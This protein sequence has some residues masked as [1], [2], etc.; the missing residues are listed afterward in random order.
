[1]NLRPPRPER[2]LFARN[3][4]NSSV[5]ASDHVRT[6]LEHGANRQERTPGILPTHMGDHSKREKRRQHAIEALER[7]R[8]SEVWT[9]PP[10][11]CGAPATHEINRGSG[12]VTFVCEKHIPDGLWVVGQFEN[13]R[14]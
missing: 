12:K 8:Q 3:G 4:G 2:G 5:F 1:M 13:G 14:A 11:H 10:C 7:G 9:P 6:M